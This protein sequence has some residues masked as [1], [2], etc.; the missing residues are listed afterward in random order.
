MKVWWETGYLHSL[1][2]SPILTI[3]GE[4]SNCIVEQF[5]GKELTKWLK[6]VSPVIGSMTSHALW[7]WCAK[8]NY[9]SVL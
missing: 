9:P 1:K 6:F 4:N 7:L 5:S 8:E 2:V 3:K